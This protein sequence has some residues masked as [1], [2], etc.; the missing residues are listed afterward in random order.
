MA[1][2]A[3]GPELLQVMENMTPEQIEAFLNRSL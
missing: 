1:G 3:S 2:K